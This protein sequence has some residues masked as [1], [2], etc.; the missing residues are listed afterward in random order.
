M[1]GR[2]RVLNVAEKPS[3]SRE[4]SNC[5]SGGTA[6]R[7]NAGYSQ[8]SGQRCLQLG[9]RSGSHAVYAAGVSRTMFLTIALMASSAIWS[10]PLL[11]DTC[12]LSTFQTVTRSGTAVHLWTCT[13]LRLSSLCL[14]S[15][16]TLQEGHRSHFAIQ[17]QHLATCRTRWISKSTWSSKPGKAT[18]WSCG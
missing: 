12:S 13:L 10:F 5:L 6:R 9:T 2:I 4:V 15:A 7:L 14:R 11:L 16:C 8:S 18:G 3:V 17:R 1:P